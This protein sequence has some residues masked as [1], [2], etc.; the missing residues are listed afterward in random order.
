[1]EH[2]LN[3]IKEELP[4]ASV[5]IEILVAGKIINNKSLLID[6]VYNKVWLESIKEK[7]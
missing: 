3:R 1:M 7:G 4:D 2:V 6:L 5:P